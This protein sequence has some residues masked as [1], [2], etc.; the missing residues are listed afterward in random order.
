MTAAAAYAAARARLHRPTPIPAV[1]RAPGKS[2]KSAASS[3]RARRC[4]RTTRRLVAPRRPPRRVRRVTAHRCR[5]AVG[6]GRHQHLVGADRRARRVRHDN[7]G[8][9]RDGRVRSVRPLSTA[10]K[11]PPWR[12]TAQHSRRGA[13]GSHIH[14]HDSRWRGERATSKT[15]R[16]QA[17]VVSVPSPLR[18]PRPA[19]AGTLRLRAAGRR[20]GRSAAAPLRT[21]TGARYAPAAMRS[22]RQPA[23]TARTARLVQ[24]GRPRPRQRAG[25]RLWQVATDAG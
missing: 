14:W 21:T 6:S 18:G 8:R 9:V 5:R 19:S 1:T 17:G 15:R 2:S 22:A 10:R 25:S 16:R 20:P 24:E 3:P 11:T 12:V 7:L 13:T 4:P 23:E